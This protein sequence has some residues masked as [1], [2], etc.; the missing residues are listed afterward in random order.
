MATVSLRVRCACGAIGGCSCAAVAWTCP[1]CARRWV[2][3][4]AAMRAADVAAAQLARLRRTVGIAV[5][6]TLVGGVVL[7]AIRP[8]W[9]LGVPVL[10]GGVLLALRPTYSAWRA[11]A[12][13]GLPASIGLTAGGATSETHR[14]ETRASS[15][16]STVEN[17]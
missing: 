1:S 12:I 13:A 11:R 3:D 6:A 9:G 4:P 5:L 2:P 8:Q 7:A 14:G 15:P 17:Q 10:V 16:L